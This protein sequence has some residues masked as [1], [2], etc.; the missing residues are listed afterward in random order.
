MACRP[1]FFFYYLG[2]WSLI[3]LFGVAVI[4]M[5]I[6][7]VVPDGACLFRSLAVSLVYEITGRRVGGGTEWGMETTFADVI[8][9]IVARWIRTLVALSLKN[10][11]PVV[12]SRTVLK[13]KLLSLIHI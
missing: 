3:F 8:H 2:V 9:N 11:Q 1:L 4:K 7:Q 13:G 5:K 10:N 12:T 6:I